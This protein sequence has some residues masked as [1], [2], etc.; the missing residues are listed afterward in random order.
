M[1]RLARLLP[2]GPGAAASC[3]L[4]TVAWSKLGT[5]S[6]FS[7]SLALFCLLPVSPGLLLPRA[8][9]RRRGE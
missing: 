8:E 6:I 7:A 9:R 4:S 3:S 5:T 2:M 1:T